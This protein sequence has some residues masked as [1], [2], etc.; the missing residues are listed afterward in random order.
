MTTPNWQHHSKKEQ[1]RKL[2]PQALR[3]RKEALR[4]LKKMLNV[5]KTTLSQH[6]LTIYYRIGDNDDLNPLLLLKVVIG[7]IMHNLI[8]HNQL[9]GWKQS[10][11]RLSKV[12]DQTTYESDI[13]NDYYDCLIECDDDQSKCKRIC[14]SILS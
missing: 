9:A 12:L 3:Q 14:R 13:L 1:K 10:A 7:G 8:S 2:K 6:T 11:E 5:T 4:Y